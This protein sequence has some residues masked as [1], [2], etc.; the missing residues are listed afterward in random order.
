MKIHVSECPLFWT[1]SFG[2]RAICGWLSSFPIRDFNICP[3]HQSVTARTARGDRG[4]NDQDGTPSPAY[5]VEIEPQR[6]DL[7]PAKKHNQLTLF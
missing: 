5:V 4:Q 1:R 6:M 2:G 3:R 7:Y